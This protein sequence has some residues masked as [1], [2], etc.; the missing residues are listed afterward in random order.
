[1][2]SVGRQRWQRRS[3]PDEAV[4]TA[5]VTAAQNNDEKAMLD[6]SDRR[7]ANRLVGAEIEAAQNRANFVPR[8][9]E[10]TSLG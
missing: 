9:P 10:C 6:V 1:V 5:L 8:Y 2:R 4:A 3:S 7:K